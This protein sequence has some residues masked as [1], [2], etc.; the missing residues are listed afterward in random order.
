[1]V[2]R[3]E[4]YVNVLNSYLRAL[5]SISADARWSAYGVEWRGVGRNI[6]SLILRFNQT[7][8]LNTEITAGWAKLSGQY[9]GYMSERYMRN[10]QAKTVRA[11]VN[12]GDT[13]VAACAELT[14]NRDF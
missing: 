9:I 2:S 10:R 11:F 4:V 12:E 7:E 13:R 6:D 3:A 1:M 5:R 8:L 14:E